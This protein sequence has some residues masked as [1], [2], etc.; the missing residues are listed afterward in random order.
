MKKT[1]FRLLSNDQLSPAIQ[2]NTRNTRRRRILAAICMALFLSA[3]GVKSVAQERNAVFTVR[4]NDLNYAVQQS[5]ANAGKVIGTVLEAL[6]G[7]STNTD[8]SLFAPAVSS[9]VRSG[10]SDVRRLASLASGDGAQFDLSGDITSI[11]THTSSR[12]VE[13][14]DSKGKVYKELVNNYEASIGVTLTLTELATGQQWTN[15]FSANTVW[16]EGPTSEA[17][18]FEMAADRLKGEI[19]KAYN[20]MFPLVAEIVE[21]GAS[22]KDKQ[23]DVY[24]DLGEAE[25]VKKGMHFEVFQLSSVAGHE[26]RKHLGKLKVEET[27]GDD[28]S[29]CKVEKG[30]KEIK[31]AIDG[32]E[33]LLV[34]S[35]D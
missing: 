30:S 11:V 10:I 15:S 33:T 6:A 24:I 23:K 22:K 13:R 32:G 8:N 29:R 7:E 4:V 28:I 14:K 20:T 2:P 18:A 16:Y 12:T 5:K 31:A 27:M 21:G 9:A 1:A 17:Q 3:F 25:G 34:T 19:T 26:T 35:I